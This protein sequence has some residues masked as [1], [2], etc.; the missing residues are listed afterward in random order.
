MLRNHNTIRACHGTVTPRWWRQRVSCLAQQGAEW[1][2]A[3]T[4]PP[5]TKVRFAADLRTLKAMTTSATMPLMGQAAL[6]LIPQSVQLDCGTD[7][8]FSAT[9]DCELQLVFGIPQQQRERRR[10]ERCSFSRLVAS[11]HAVR[12]GLS[13]CL[14]AISTGLSHGALISYNC[15]SNG[16][17]DMGAG[18]AMPGCFLRELHPRSQAEFGVHVRE[19]RLH[20]AG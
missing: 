10:Q 1:A 7:C 5:S 3:A 14:R 17:S 4:C 20:G 9:C 12:C 13:G 15:A 8:N 11:G 18:S 2:G 6:R 16:L 19:M